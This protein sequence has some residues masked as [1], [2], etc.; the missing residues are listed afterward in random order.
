[1]M[2][3][4]SLLLLETAIGADILLN[5]DWEKVYLLL[6]PTI[7]IFIPYSSKF[8]FALFHIPKFN[9]WLSI[10]QDLPNDPTGRFKDFKDFVK[11]NFE[12]FKWIGLFIVLAQVHYYYYYFSHFTFSIELVYIHLVKC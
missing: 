12:I 10:F 6:E 5:S 7:F 4:F 3:I 11:S 1:M 2:I 9:F 8:S